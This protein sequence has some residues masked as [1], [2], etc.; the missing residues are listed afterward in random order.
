MTESGRKTYIPNNTMVIEIRA[1]MFLVKDAAL[2]L[3][4]RKSKE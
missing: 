4:M 1:Y 2:N 3:L